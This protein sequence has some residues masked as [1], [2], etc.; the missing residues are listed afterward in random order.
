MTD[1]EENRLITLQQVAERLSICARG[2]LRAVARGEL[3][4]PVKVGR[5]SRWIVSDV[6][7]Y[8][9]RLKCQRDRMSGRVA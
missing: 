9:N 2:V 5:A 4:R 6:E 3:A 8:I 1:V 7:A